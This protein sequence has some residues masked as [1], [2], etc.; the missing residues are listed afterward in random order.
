[1]INP[2]EKIQNPNN[3]SL[4]DI[5]INGEAIYLVWILDFGFRI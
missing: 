2:N 4:R 3:V 5:I 1:M